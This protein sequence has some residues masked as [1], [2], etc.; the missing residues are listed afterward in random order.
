[1]SLQAGQTILDGKYR[2]LKLIGEGG[3]ARVWLAEEPEFGGRRVAIK[4]PS[5]GQL[6]AAE[7]QELEHRFQQEA[8][9]A[10]Q[11]EQAG[12][13]NV[14]RAYTLERLPDGTQLLVLEYMAGGSV[15]ELIAAHPDGMPVERAL[16]ITQDIL[17]ALG[18]F[19]RLS[20]APVHRDVKPENIL[21]DGQ[22][23]ARLSDLGLAQLPGVSGRSQL[24]ASPHPGTPLYMAPEQAT[25]PQPLMPA[26]DLYALGCVLF[27]MLT[28]QRYKRVRPG[29]KASSLRPEVPGWLDKVLAKTLA[30]DPWDRYQKAEE[31]AAALR[32][33]PTSAASHGRR[34]AAGA[35]PVATPASRPVT[36][37]TSP[38]SRQP[39]APSQRPTAN[40]WV[41]WLAGA[42][43]LLAIILAAL[44]IGLL[45]SNGYQGIEGSTTTATS[46]PLALVSTT[47][48]PSRTTTVTTAPSK[49]PT[50][51]ISPTAIPPLEA[52][53]MTQGKIVFVRDDQI[54]LMDLDGS[55]KVQLTTDGINWHPSWSPDGWQ[56]V[57]QRHAPSDK[58][59]N[60]WVMDADGG[61]QHAITQ[62]DDEGTIKENAQRPVWSPDGR[63]IAVAQELS[64]SEPVI[65]EGPFIM[66]MNS[67]GDGLI[68]LAEGRD[69][70]WSPDSRQIA[71]LSGL[72]QATRI[73][74]INR[75]GTGLTYLDSSFGV[76][77]YPAWSPDG[78]RI[79]LAA[80][81]SLDWT[82]SVLSI[83][84]GSM[85]R[86]A[87]A[88]RIWGIN[89]S[90]DGTRILYGDGV[91]V[92]DV[93][94]SNQVQ[95]TSDG[96]QPAWQPAV[97]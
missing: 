16:S 54:W 64:A 37:A 69:P 52:D 24:G 9:L 15:A 13:P 44:I 68:R 95:L 22:G 34:P 11:L 46:A 29:T 82:L 4:E 19:H 21:L 77:M 5:L 39:S 7:R 40:R 66:L 70:T 65:T 87:T 81:T 2:I 49:T 84:N 74:I 88:P 62:W 89:W 79:A 31:M 45:T 72:G 18:G 51:T 61:N 25:S 63:Y 41:P 3:M 28:G 36:P 92:I 93:D 97:P 58:I 67:D 57:W 91:S 38:P 42:V 96:S 27:E 59:F 60:V 6:G 43:G 50:A 12:V 32:A 20:I 75:D 26:A 35:P 48:T 83:E 94:G 55:H 86:L 10:P 73:G 71:F 90:P 78:K 23:R 17:Q 30:E 1:M 56:I 80:T 33:A 14:V 47:T 53:A 85:Q 8:K 76:P